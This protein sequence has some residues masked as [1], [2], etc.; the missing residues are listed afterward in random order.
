MPT[1]T[2]Q[3]SKEK[4]AGAIYCNDEKNLE[5]AACRLGIKIVS[6]GG[7]IKLMGEEEGVVRGL[8]L[9]GELMALGAEG[10]SITPEQFRLSLDAVAEGKRGVAREI[11]GDRIEVMSRKRYVTPR[12]PGQRA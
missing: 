2:I 11:I 5:L 7:M 6:R 3:F 10:E 12:T 4:S 9:F 1:E 8:E